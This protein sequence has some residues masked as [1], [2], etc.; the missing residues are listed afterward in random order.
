MKIVVFCH[1]VVEFFILSNNNSFHM[2]PKYNPEIH[3]RRSIR[4]KEYDYSNSGAYYV[5]ICT[6]NRECI[7]GKIVNAEIKL[8]PVGQIVQQEWCNISS[9][10]QD[11]ELDEF[12]IMPNNLHGIIM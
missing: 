7:F 5:T 11:I 4:L 8:S 12:I 6:W 3:Q 1:F 2:A 10:F 9:R